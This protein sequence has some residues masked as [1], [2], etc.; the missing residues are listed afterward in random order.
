MISWI[1][2]FGLLFILLRLLFWSFNTTY[3]IFQTRPRLS[4]KVVRQGWALPSF[5]NL[6]PRG[7]LFPS[8]PPPAFF[9]SVYMQLCLACMS[10][11]LQKHKIPQTSSYNGDETCGTF[12]CT[13]AVR[14]RGISA[15]Y[16]SLLFQYHKPRRP[17]M[18]LLNDK[19]TYS[20]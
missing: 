19:T 20:G 11:R 9:L 3:P 5:G 17:V 15:S 2:L 16:P 10:H 14:Q 12:L 7:T 13:A 8:A 1:V 18:L 4:L 6:P